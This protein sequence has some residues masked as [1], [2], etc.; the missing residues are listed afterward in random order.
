LSLHGQSQACVKYHKYLFYRAYQ[1]KV[2]R[3]IGEIKKGW[4]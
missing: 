4:S 1:V 3:R 2:R